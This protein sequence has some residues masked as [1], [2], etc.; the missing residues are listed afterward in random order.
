MLV[1]C[2]TKSKSDVVNDIVGNNNDVSFSLTMEDGDG[3]SKVRELAQGQGGVSIGFTATVYVDGDVITKDVVSLN[4][5]NDIEWATLQHTYLNASNEEVVENY[6][7]AIK[8]DESNNSHEVYYLNSETGEY[9]YYG[10]GYNPNFDFSFEQLEEYLTLDNAYL[11]AAVALGDNGKYETL[12]G[13]RCLTFGIPGERVNLPEGRLEVSFDLESRLLMKMH[14]NYI[15]RTNDD[16]IIHAANVDV[17]S[18]T[19]AGPAPTLTK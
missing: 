5:V 12:A 1:S 7:G 19:T 9:E 13:R 2:N 15:E 3:S 18:F 16:M 11:A 14:A 6:A 10:T 4:R 8:I 17:G